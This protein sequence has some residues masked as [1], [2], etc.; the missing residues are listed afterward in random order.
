MPPV[1][2]TLRRVIPA[3]IVAFAALVGNAASG[4][5]TRTVKV[6]VPYAPGGGADA[7]ARILADQIG[8]LREATMV[9]ENRPGAG[10][11]IAA[12]AVARAAHDGNTLL[13]AD[14]NLVI[15]PHVRKLNY[16]PLVSFEPICQL[17]SSPQV[18]V[19]NSASPYRGLAD[20]LEAA[21]ARPGALTLASVGPVSLPRI[22]FEQLKRA[23]KVN[24]T[25]VTYPGAAP[26][27]SALLG[28]HVSSAL[29]SYASVAEQIKAGTLRAIAVTT[30]GR[31]D[32]L[33]DVPTI[34]EAGYDDYELD[35][36]DGVVAPAKTSQESVT[37][38]AGWFTAAVQ[39]PETKR[40]LVGQ[41]LFPVV[42]CGADFAAVIRKQYDEYGRIIR[43]ANI[44]AE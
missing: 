44:E 23:A 22:G 26:A 19:V 14:S 20:L 11:V 3:A 4:Q 35:L 39:D 25:F 42:T 18:L 30:R 41:G 8:R 1:G 31:V 32:A 9:I 33:P 7:F 17:V 12:E 40:K 28:G 24:I 27:A 34:A 29:L 37:Q 36:W 5:T 10:T 2:L 16:D 6:V 43:Q 21:R 38:I 15:M 13:V